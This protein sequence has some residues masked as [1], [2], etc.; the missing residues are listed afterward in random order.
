M[1]L[2]IAFLF[3]LALTCGLQAAPP[4]I[5]L[6]LADDLGY[7]DLKSYAEDSQI[8]TP[9]LDR[10]AAEG[11]RFTQA[12]CPNAVCSPTRYALLTGEYPWRSWKKAGVL[13]NWDAPM[14]KREQASLP[15]VLREAGYA[16][17]GF[18]KWHLGVRYETTDGKAPAGQ[19]KFKSEPG[20]GA[21]LDLNKPIS[22]GPVENGFQEWWGFSCASETLIFDGDQFAALLDHEKYRD[23]DHPAFASKPRITLAEYL[24]EMTKRSVAFIEKTAGGTKP[25]FLY[26]APY[27][28][29]IP[30]AVR[31]EFRG[32]TKA[33][34]YGDYVAE[35]DHHVGL[36]LAALEKMK[37]SENTLILFVSDNGSEFR[38]SGE[39]HRPNGSL[40]GVK[41]N[42]Y[43]GGVRSPFILRWPAAIPAQSVSEEIVCFTDVLP[44]LAK[45]AGAKLPTGAAQDGLDLSALMLGKENP[46]TVRKEV[47]VQAA[48]TVFGLRQEKLKLIVDRTRKSNGKPELYDLAADPGET[49]NMAA[50]SPE[51][52]EKMKARLEEMLS[53]EFGKKGR[54]E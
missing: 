7:G 18:G 48:Q 22:R 32:K 16:T 1:S 38:T 29:H 49:R 47:V 5:V 39:N 45:I 33:G 27:V 15:R 11:R 8:P 26:F 34:D 46:P 40:R 53:E 10:L 52:V 36:L 44:S 30:L 25:F 23:L 43:E 54:A 50:E 21:N 12:Y 2:R 9:H 42:V 20:S 6:I 13:A 14:I 4:N 28:P 35:L 24:P 17:G 41:S 19:G 37:A 3:L 31:E 51:V